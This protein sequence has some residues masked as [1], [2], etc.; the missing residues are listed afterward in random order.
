MRTHSLLLVF[1]LLGP[2]AACE[3][4]LPEIGERENGIMFGQTDPGHLSIGLL[5]LGA[6]L[7]G[8][9]LVLLLGLAW[10]RSSGQS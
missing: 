1:A 4:G 8:G 10:L 7:C 9:T 2:G 3:P 5:S 6:K